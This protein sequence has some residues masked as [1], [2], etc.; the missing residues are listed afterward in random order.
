MRAAKAAAIKKLVTNQYR[1]Y[2]NKPKE[3]KPLSKIEQLR[4]LIPEYARDNFVVTIRVNRDC[5]QCYTK[6]NF[7]DMCFFNGI[8]IIRCKD[9]HIHVCFDLNDKKSGKNMQEIGID[10]EK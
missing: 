9:C 4:K 1:K 3:T 10:Y 5:P 7:I 6:L 8:I 2:R